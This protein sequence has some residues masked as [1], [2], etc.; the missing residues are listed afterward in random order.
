MK[1]TQGILY[2]TIAVLFACNVDNIKLDQQDA[3]WALPLVQG[4]IKVSDL[5]GKASSRASIQVLPDGILNLKYTGDVLQKTKKDIF[6]PIP[7]GIPI[8]MFDTVNLVTLP[9]VNNVIIK[10]AILSNGNY[11]VQ[12]SHNR[13]ESITLRMWVP[14]M[15]LNNQYININLNVPYNGTLPV[16]G[17]SDKFSFENILMIPVNNRIGLH[18]Q[19]TTANQ[20]SFKM[21]GMFFVYDQ[22]DFKYIEGF[23]GQNVYDLQKDSIEIDL[24]D[25]FVKG[26]IYVDDPTVTVTVNSSFG[27]PTKALVNQFDLET[28]DGSLIT[29]KSKLLDDGMYFNYPRLS[30]SGKTKSTTFVFNKNNSNIRDI[31]NAQARRVIYDIDA[32]SNPLLTPDSTSF[33]SENSKFAI[34]LTVDLP[35]KGTVSQYPATKTFETDASKLKDL[36]EGFMLIES[37]NHIALAANAQLYFYDASNQIIDS[38]FSSAQPLFK[39]AL[40]NAQ[41]ISITPSSNTLMIPIPATKIATWSTIKKIKLDAVFNTNN[42]NR[43]V[44][45]AEKDVLTLK[46]GFVGKFKL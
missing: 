25:G 30:E 44:Q 29:F 46:L 11:Y 6:F 23:I 7:G 5:I 18:Y 10:K 33:I 26:S 43:L 22:I 45:I 38:A 21:S 1:L 14:E 39:A 27:F 12:Y 2:I 4:E 9:I 16:F 37:L 40:T 13:P 36:K 35:L 31:F 42:N 19:A 41:G 32:L 34:Y 3:E 17:S 15:S 8:P 28:K 24:Y 20:E